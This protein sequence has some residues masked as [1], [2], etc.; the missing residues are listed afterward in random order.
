MAR[1][2]TSTQTPDTDT[3]QTG[4]VGE[5]AWSACFPEGCDRLDLLL[6]TSGEARS[7]LMPP[8]IPGRDRSIKSSK[9][10]IASDGDLLRKGDGL[11]ATTRVTATLVEGFKVFSGAQHP[12]A[13]VQ[14]SDQVVE[15]CRIC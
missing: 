6:Q 4:S 7:A 3:T 5:K 8:T 14:C 11:S 9:S 13:I 2:H 12:I 1:A 10:G 15:F